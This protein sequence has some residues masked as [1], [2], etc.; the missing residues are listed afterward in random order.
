MAATLIFICVCAVLRNAI[1]SSDLLPLIAMI[2]AMLLL[3]SLS[4]GPQLLRDD[5][6]KDLALAGDYWAG[7]SNAS[8]FALNSVEV[9][10]IVGYPCVSLIDLKY[11][12]H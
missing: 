3:W 10:F 8:T 4:L 11:D 2:T 5:L 6:R 9:A 1:G 7:C 12:T